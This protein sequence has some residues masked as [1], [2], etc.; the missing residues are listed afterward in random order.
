MLKPMSSRRPRVLRHRTIY[1]G[2]IFQVERDDVR[3][4][5]G[6]RV[7]LEIVRHRGSVVLLPQPTARHIVLVRQF[8]YAINRWLWEL[9]AGS[10]EPGE[11]PAQCARRE[12][13]EEVGLTPGRVT[14]L[15]TFYPT[16][17]FCDETMV[18]FRCGELRPPNREIARDEDEQ[19]QP[20]VF[21]V[22][23]ASQMVA[24]GRI[25]DMKTV[26]GLRLVRT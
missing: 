16:P 12:C 18:F 14:R 1:R 23:E 5:N 4:T 11:S 2:R 8:R 6:R 15:G 26:L 19:L 7:E 3:L 20:R 9:P 17:G 13:E 21:S 25:V 10:L 24:R 22:A